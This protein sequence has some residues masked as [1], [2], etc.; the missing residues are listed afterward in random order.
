M[1]PSALRIPAIQLWTI[2]E[3]VLKLLG[4][5]LRTPMN[6]LNIARVTDIP[7]SDYSKPTAQIRIVSQGKQRP[8]AFPCLSTNTKFI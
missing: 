6:E 2:K 3:A 8:L 1:E 5:G 4:T 7:V